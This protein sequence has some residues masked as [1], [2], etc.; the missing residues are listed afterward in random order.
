MTESSGNVDA[1]M[2][3]DNLGRQIGMLSTQLAMRD[4]A[5]EVAERR[6]TDAELRCQELQDR[7]DQLEQEPPAPPADDQGFRPPSGPPTGPAFDGPPPALP[8]P[9]EPPTTVIKAPAGKSTR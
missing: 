3:I 9:D 1:Q 2:V 6:A 4:V 5:M 8:A 7:L